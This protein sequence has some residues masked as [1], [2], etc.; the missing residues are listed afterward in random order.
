MCGC[1]NTMIKKYFSNFTEGN[2]REKVRFTSLWLMRVLAIGVIIFS[3]VELLIEGNKSNYSHYINFMLQS[4]V[5]IG[6]SIVPALVEKIWKVK[7]P[8]TIVIIFLF[9]SLCAFFFG[10]IA[11]FYIKYEWWDDF[12]H[13]FAGLYIASCAIFLLQIMNERRDIP[14]KS[15]PGFVFFFALVTAMACEAVWEIIE[16]SIDGILIKNMQRAYLSQQFIDNGPITDINNPLFNARV[17]RDA[18]N[19][20]MGDIIEVLIGALVTCTIGYL[21]LKH[22]EKIKKLLE[23][24]PKKNKSSNDDDKELDDTKSQDIIEDNSPSSIEKEVVEQSESQK[25]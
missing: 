8:F 1:D 14:Y 23:K 20:T 10:E 15:S 3:I 17:G 9:M 21:A 22:D 24:M 4:L 19:D 2:K 25:E 18:L 7:L 13:T 16:Y 12:L 6:L 11:D 5:L